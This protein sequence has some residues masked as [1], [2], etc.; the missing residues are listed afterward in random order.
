M[1]I[2]EAIQDTLP[3]DAAVIQRLVGQTIAV[4]GADGFVGR[5][6]CG[7]AEALGVRVLRIVRRKSGPGAH[8]CLVNDL[9]DDAR[10]GEYL[11]GVTAVIHLAGRAHVLRERDANPR[12]LFERANVEAS[13]NLAKACTENNVRRLVYVS[14]IGVNGEMTR[15]RP[16]DESD[17]PSPSSLYAES[18]LKAEVLL[19]EFSTKHGLEL[20]IVRPPLVYGPGAP[21]NFRRLV[22]LAG[23][24]LPLPFAAIRNRRSLIGVENLTDF[25]VLCT[26]HRSAPGETFLIAEK[27]PRATPELIEALGRALGQP[28]RLFPMPLNILRFL[29]NVL[30]KGAEME[31]FCG[32]LE[33]SS[34]K[35]SRVLGW[36]PRVTFEQQIAEI[37]NFERRKRDGG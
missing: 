14:S 10:L 17:T 33:V 30:G 18:K 5:V 26:S 35:A 11:K 34:E 4:T 31:K 2:G 23:G 13:L 37:A 12:A 29:A 36:H 28:V 20:V 16:F 22:R 24:G 27:T 1:G 9:A 15:E 32:S 8:R 19:R 3:L 7:R 25:L 21:G 6:L